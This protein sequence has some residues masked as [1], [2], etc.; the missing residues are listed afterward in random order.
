MGITSFSPK[1]PSLKG[2]LH[3]VNIVELDSDSSEARDTG[4]EVSHHFNCKTVRCVRTLTQLLNLM[5]YRTIY[6]K[7]HYN[8]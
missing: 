5:L 4:S 7:V 1:N 2:Y 6:P 3:P 8:Q